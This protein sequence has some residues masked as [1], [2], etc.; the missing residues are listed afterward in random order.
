VEKFYGRQAGVDQQ[1]T[2]QTGDFVPHREE[3]DARVEK[4]KIDW[5]FLWAQRRQ[6]VSHGNGRA[7][8]GGKLAFRRLVPVGLLLVNTASGTTGPKSLQVWH[9]A[10]R[11]A[12][13]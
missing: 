11:L 5:Y 3:K 2:A 9:L 4:N 6:K 10:L 13:A 8:E 7:E 1:L 12:E